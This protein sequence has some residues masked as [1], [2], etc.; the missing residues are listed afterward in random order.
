MPSQ[1]SGEQEGRSVLY[2][3]L[4]DSIAAGVGASVPNV[5]FLERVFDY[6]GSSRTSD[7]PTFVNLAIGGETSGS[8]LS[9]QV[10]AARDALG[11]PRFDART[12]ILS[13]GGNDL[14]GLLATEPCASDP[15]GAACRQVVASTLESFARNYGEILVGLRAAIDQQAGEGRIVVITLYNPYSGTSSPL[16]DVFDLALLGA[17][18]AVDCPST[19]SSPVTVGLNDLLSCLG[20][21]QGATVVDTYAAFAGRGLELTHIGEGDIHPTDEG[22]RVIADAVIAA[23][24]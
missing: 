16:E 12:V 21:A 14:L 7:Q 2:L 24:S 17:D 11:D 8:F 5:S 15:A 1:S 13:I 20:Q 18:H 9:G 10:D 6:V 19:V 4:G 22:H 3:G 23:L